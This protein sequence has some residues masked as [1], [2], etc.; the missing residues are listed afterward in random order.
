MASFQ[1][2]AGEQI[3]LETE[4]VVWVKDNDISLKA[5]TLSN[6][7]LYIIYKKK[8]GIFLKSTIET[9]N[10]HCS[11]RTCPLAFEEKI[12]PLLGFV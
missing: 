12:Q 3:I 1:L 9:I 7:Y 6:K 8:N 4:D 5:L 11:S 2:E 10:I